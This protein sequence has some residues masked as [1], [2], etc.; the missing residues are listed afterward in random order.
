ME[1]KQS[2]PKISLIIP[3]Y[4]EEKYIGTCLDYALKSTHPFFEIIVIDNASTDK[5]S[6]IAESFSG[7]RVVRE[8][9]KGL[10]HARER[11]Q[12]EAK[13]DLLAFVDADTR[14]PADWSLKAFDTFTAHKDVVCLSGPYMYYDIPRWQQFLVVLYWRILAL[15]LYFFIRYMVV[16]GNFVIRRDTVAA[17]GGFDTSIAFYGE[18]TDIARRAAKVGKV[19]FSMAFCMPTSGRRFSGQGLIKTMLLYGAN[20]F[21]QVF[22][23]H[24]VTKD[25]K[26]IR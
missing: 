17:M 25:Y 23:H 8:E 13:G 6:D 11:G 26:D 2:S 22:L 15:P 14:M 9:K 1:I 3:A 21:S 20:F 19:K 18:D 7:V 10:V 16:G 12:R 5:T 4:N 24:A